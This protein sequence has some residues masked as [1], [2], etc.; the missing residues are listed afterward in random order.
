MASITIRNLDDPL[1]GLLRRRAANHGRSMEEEVR[2]ILREALAN[3]DRPPLDLAQAIRRRF[4]PLGGID[5]ADVARDEPRPPPG[6]D[7]DGSSA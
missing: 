7:A 4:A 6:F 2:Q 1:K 5:L 3:E